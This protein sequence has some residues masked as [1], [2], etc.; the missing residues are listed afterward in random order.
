MIKCELKEILLLLRLHHSWLITGFVTRLTRR[1]PLVER[2][3]HSIPE[4]LSSSPVISEIRVARSL[5]F[6]VC[7]VDCCLSFC[8]FL[9]A[10]MLSVLFRFTNYDYPFGIFVSSYSSYANICIADLTRFSSLRHM[11]FWLSCLCPFLPNTF[12]LFGFLIIVLLM[13]VIAE[14]I[15]VH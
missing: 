3:L 12:K 8:I 10:I 6:C 4:H 2:E 7:F 11:G 15:C 14:T 1:V 9:L 13:T 5:V